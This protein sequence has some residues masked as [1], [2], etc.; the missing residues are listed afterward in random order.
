M[1]K[2][3]FNSTIEA[4]QNSLKRDKSRAENIGLG[5]TLKPISTDPKDY[6]V[7][8]EWWKE[9]YG[10]L[11]LQF[12][13]IIQIAGDSDS[14]KTSLALEAMKRAQEQGFGVIYVETEGKTS[15]QDLIQK[16]INPDGVMTIS[17]AI[18]E[19]A[20]DS[21]LRVWNQ[22]FEDYPNEKLLFV[23]DSYGNTTSMRDSEL[24]MT[25][26]SQK[27]GGAAK[28]NRLGIGNLIARMVKD[29][30]AVLIVN[31]NYSN[32]GSVGKTNAGGNAL[33]FHAMLTIQSSRVGW[34]EA[35][36]NGIKV[37][38]GAKVR[39]NTFK[40]HYAKALVDENGNQLLFPKYIDLSIT[41]EG[42][43]RLV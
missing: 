43:K 27:P 21:S 9:A 8:P 38:K 15:P 29:P 2:F 1:S 18:T 36:Q 14:G 34:I 23:F 6:I 24:D 39:Y 28:T 25:K 12:G 42:F 20:W 3:N 40:S 11:G 7:M 33:N 31:Y 30:V 35:Q 41:A 19:E 10:V 13:K 32:I 22:F 5:N 37:K 17:S 4:V 16:G 26:D